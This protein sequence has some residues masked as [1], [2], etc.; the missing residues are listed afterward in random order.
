MCLPLPRLFF[1]CCWKGKEGVAHRPQLIAAVKLPHAAGA[2]AKEHCNPGVDRYGCCACLAQLRARRRSKVQPPHS[3][4]HQRP[5]LR[6]SLCQH[7]IAALQDANCAVK[8]AVLQANGP[9]VHNWSTE[10]TTS[11]SSL[12]PGA[13][14]GV[15][16]GSNISCLP[17]I[18]WHPHVAQEQEQ[19]FRNPTICQVVA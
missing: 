4:L 1:R 10:E 5:P 8:T 7:L 16:K 3:A 17:G 18:K 9:I 2:C 15:G 6:T 11:R 19:S 13:L 14:K 12:T